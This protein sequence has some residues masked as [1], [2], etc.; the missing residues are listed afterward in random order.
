MQA[1]DEMQACNGPSS[2][3]CTGNGTGSQLDN[4]DAAAEIAHLSMQV[5][6]EYLERYYVLIAFSA[7]LMEPGFDPKDPGRTR[8]GRWLAERPELYRCAKSAAC[9][10]CTWGQVSG[11]RCAEMS[12]ASQVMGDQMVCQ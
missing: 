10:T 1:D 7:Y 4:N 3:D 2:A 11:Q 12:S 9:Q 6:L 5:C 8:F